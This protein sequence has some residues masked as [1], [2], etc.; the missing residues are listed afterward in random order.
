MQSQPTI[1]AGVSL[2]SKAIPQFVKTWYINK[3]SDRL[4]RMGEW[5][6]RSCRM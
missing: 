6:G 1:T 4:A 2:L 5:K 3:L